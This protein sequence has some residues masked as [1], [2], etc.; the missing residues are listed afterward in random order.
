M[1]RSVELFTDSKLYEQN[2]PLF[3]MIYGTFFA[4]TIRP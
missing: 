4:K 3:E 1:I 2:A